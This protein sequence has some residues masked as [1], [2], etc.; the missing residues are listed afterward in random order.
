MDN[1]LSGAIGAILATIVA[2]I[3]NYRIFKR[4]VLIESNR[5]FLQNIVEVLRH[6]YVSERAGKKISD[7]DIN[8]L[9][10]FKIISFGD[11]NISDELDAIE[12]VIIQ[13]N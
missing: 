4:Q 13:Y 10:S 3:V 12:K 7:D 8:L 2:T 6:I 1:L 9:V 5:I 11:F